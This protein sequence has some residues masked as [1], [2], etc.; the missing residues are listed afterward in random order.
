MIDSQKAEQMSR[1]REPRAEVLEQI[2]TTQKGNAERPK[3]GEGGKTR[4]D[5]IMSYL[6]NIEEEFSQMSITNRSILPDRS[7]AKDPLS[8][9]GKARGGMAAISAVED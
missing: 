8:T 2:T 4:Y 1:Q 7:P 3:A 9:P 6:G 5:E